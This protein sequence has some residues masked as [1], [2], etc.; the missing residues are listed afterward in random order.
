MMKKIL[1]TLLFVTPMAIA[2]GMQCG[3]FHLEAAGDGFM[4]INGQRTETQKL[5]FLKQKEDYENL[6][7][8]WMVPTAEPGHWFGMDYVKKDGKAILNVQIVQADMDAPRVYGTYDCV[9]MK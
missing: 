7:L 6:M 9:R 3:P 1:V 4:H 2:G 5:T 8:Q